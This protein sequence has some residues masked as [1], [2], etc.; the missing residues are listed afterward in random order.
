MN[1]RD[2]QTHHF[3]RRSPASV[4]PNRQTLSKRTLANETLSGAVGISQTRPGA[5]ISDF[6]ASAVS[7]GLFPETL[8]NGCSAVLILEGGASL[9]RSWRCG[10]IY[11]RTRHTEILCAGPRS[12]GSRKSG[13]SPRPSRAANP[14]G[15]RLT[16]SCSGAAE[17]VTT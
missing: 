8:L 5:E 3:D 16:R 4:Y 14:S 1:V 17:Q 12:S 13:V 15:A 2:G 9:G 11:L 6:Q 7:S 10:S